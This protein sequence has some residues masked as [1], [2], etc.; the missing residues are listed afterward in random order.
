MFLSILA[1]SFIWPK[2]TNEF[3][4]RVISLVI[5]GVFAF[6]MDIIILELTAA[7][8]FPGAE[9]WPHHPALA[10]A[11]TEL[12]PMHHHTLLHPA[13]QAQVPVRSYL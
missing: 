7:A 2:I 4:S 6:V 8:F 11:P 1:D 10:Y 13:L 9:I 5:S 3:Q 12:T